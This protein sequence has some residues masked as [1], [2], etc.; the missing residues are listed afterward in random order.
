MSDIGDTGL[1]LG[2]FY[3]LCTAAYFSARLISGEVVEDT[4]VR[5]ALRFVLA[6]AVTLP[7]RFFHM[8]TTLN[9]KPYSKL[10][11]GS[12]LPNV[13]Q[14]FCFFY[15]ADLLSH[16]LGLLKMQQRKLKEDEESGA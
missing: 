12:L 4:W 7:W 2:A 15:V 1:I 3:G 13:L 8:L 9:D 5:F 16:H 10:I 6:L 11:Y 14:G